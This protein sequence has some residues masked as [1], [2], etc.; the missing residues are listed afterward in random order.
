MISKLQPQIRFLLAL[1]TLSLFF[2]AAL[3]ANEV[4]LIVGDKKQQKMRFGIDY[5]RLWFW[6][7]RFDDEE[8]ALL[9]K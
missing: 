1:F 2:A 5:E 4:E 7:K 9:E 3:D 6:S 8:R